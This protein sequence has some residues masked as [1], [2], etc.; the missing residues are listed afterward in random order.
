MIRHPEPVV[1][2]WGKQETSH[3]PCVLILCSLSLELGLPRGW[4]LRGFR[5]QEWH[6]RSCALTRVL[7]SSWWDRDRIRGTGQEATRATQ[8][9]AGWT[10][11]NCSRVVGSVLGCRWRQADGLAPGLCLQARLCSQH[12]AATWDS[13]EGF[14]RC[15]SWS[16]SYQRSHLTIKYKKYKTTVITWK[17]SPKLLV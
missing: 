1:D 17:S 6:D 15:D 9:R 7:R 5:V 3:V 13:F 12:T 8:L 10:M 14:H 16:K 4:Q 2:V 11:A